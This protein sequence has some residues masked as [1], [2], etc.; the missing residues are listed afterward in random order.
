MFKIPEL[1][2]LNFKN[3]CRPKL[4]SAL[5]SSKVQTGLHFLMSLGAQFQRL[6]EETFLGV[7]VFDLSK[8]LSG[9]LFDCIFSYRDISL[10]LSCK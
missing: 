7:K 4:T 1:L 3:L 5:V 9:F 2:Y 10:D 6:L 8:F